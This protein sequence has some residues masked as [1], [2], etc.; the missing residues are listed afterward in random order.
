MVW[1]SLP[2][3]SSK[4]NGA[5]TCVRAH[6]CNNLVTLA[7]WDSYTTLILTP[8]ELHSLECPMSLVQLAKQL[9]LW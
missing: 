3:V 5:K 4:D 7:I 6:P 9:S 2:K 1:I 8:I